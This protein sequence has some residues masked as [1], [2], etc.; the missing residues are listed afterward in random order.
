GVLRL[1][2]VRRPERPPL[3]A[4]QPA[5]PRPRPGVAG[6]HPGAGSRRYALTL[7]PAPTGPGYGGVCGG[8][9][10]PA[11]QQSV[12]RPTPSPAV[13]GPP[14][15]PWRPPRP[16]VGY[17]RGRLLSLTI[18]RLPMLRLCG[19]LLEAGAVR[20][21]SMMWTNNTTTDPAFHPP[22]GTRSAD[23]FR[24]RSVPLPCPAGDWRTAVSSPS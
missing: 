10:V 7:R 20:S 6:P 18:R 24:S 2:R 5:P 11:A 14:P 13:T 19:V 3:R 16:G 8:S 15:A 1:A 4:G 22:S 12:A 9:Q 23:A 21:N 17:L